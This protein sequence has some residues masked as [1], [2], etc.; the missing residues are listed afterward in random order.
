MA[1]KVHVTVSANDSTPASS[2]A[3]H[4]K[5]ESFNILAGGKLH[6][7]L[8]IMI[9]I[10]VALMF[11]TGFNFPGLHG[12]GGG[13]NPLHLFD[14]LGEIMDLLCKL[15]FFALSNIYI[16][17]IAWTLASDTKLARLIRQNLP[18]PIVSSIVHEMSLEHWIN[19]RGQGKD[20]LR[21]FFKSS[22]DK[23]PGEFLD[24]AGEMQKL[25]NTIKPPPET[26]AQR[27]VAS[28]LFSNIT[29]DMKNATNPK[30]LATALKKVM[31]NKAYSGSK[32]YFNRVLDELE[33]GQISQEW[34]TKAREFSTTTH[35]FQL[36]TLKCI[37]ETEVKDF[38]ERAKASG[39]AFDEKA[40]LSCMLS[41][42][43]TTSL[44]SR[45]KRFVKGVF[46]A[47]GDSTNKDDLLNKFKEQLPPSIDETKVDKL[48]EKLAQIDFENID[49]DDVNKT[50]LDTIK[51]DPSWEPIADAYAKDDGTV[52]NDLK[53]ASARAKIGEKAFQELLSELKKGNVERK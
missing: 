11:L 9:V 35:N 18:F 2:D 42:P 24:E 45:M 10:V 47:K 39:V 6:E 32:D 17:I 38:I 23:V 20:T 22:G 37:P 44:L 50:V 53:E 3:K 12:P 26:D 1:E 7:W 28:P 19:G 27:F 52:A 40:L 4:H 15:A 41:R 29:E 25:F 8:I 33:S 48:L 43:R 14:E 31:G 30:E 13:N 34:F 16:P 49:P 21:S 51:E 46:A 36:R 5:G